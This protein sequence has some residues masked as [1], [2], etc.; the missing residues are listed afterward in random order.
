M[1]R[2]GTSLLAS[3]IFVIGG[4]IIDPAAAQSPQAH[5]LTP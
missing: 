1:T 3:S 5:H 2:F 4:L